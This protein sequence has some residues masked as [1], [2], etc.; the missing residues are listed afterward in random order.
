MP[1][2]QGGGSVVGGHRS[3]G[4]SVDVSVSH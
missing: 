2:R 1:T 4:V 3:P